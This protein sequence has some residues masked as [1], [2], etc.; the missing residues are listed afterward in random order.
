MRDLKLSI[1]SW[2]DVFHGSE[3]KTLQVSTALE[4]SK[5]HP[6]LIRLRTSLTE[7]IPL[8]RCPNI[9]RFLIQQPRKRT[10]SALVSPI[11][12][13]A[14]TPSIPTPT[15]AYAALSLPAVSSLHTALSLP[16]APTAPAAQSLSVEHPT[17]SIPQPRVQT[18]AASS[19]SSGS[20]RFPDSYT[21]AEHDSAW[22]RFE[23]QQSRARLGLGKMWPE[24]FPGSRYV[25]TTSGTWRGFFTNAVVTHQNTGQ[26]PPFLLA[27]P[28]APL[29]SIPPPA[30]LPLPPSV[31]ILEASN[32]SDAPLA[33]SSSP[34]DNPHGLCEFCDVPYKV[35]PSAKLL[36][37]R[38]QLFLI[39]TL[40][41]NFFNPAHR[42][43]HSQARVAAYCQ[44][45]DTD[46]ALMPTAR[47]HGWPEHI[48]FA[49]LLERRDELVSFLQE[50]LEDLASS[51]FFDDACAEK[52][53][54]KKT[55]Y[56]GQIG[57]NAIE[58]LIRDMF[59]VTTIQDDFHPLT[60]DGLVDVLVLEAL[61][62][63]I[64]GQFNVDPDTAALILEESTP[65]GHAYHS[66]IDDR[67]RSAA[68]FHEEAP[69][70]HDLPIPS[71]L[72]SPVPPAPSLPQLRETSPSPPPID[73][74][75][76]CPFCDEALPAD[77]S[78]RL[79]AMGKKLLSSSWPDPLPDNPLHRK[80]PTMSLAAAYCARHRFEHTELQ[81]ALLH[82]WPS[83][84]DFQHL[85]QRVLA[86]A[87][88]LRGVIH[89]YLDS[90][91]FFVAARA[92]YGQQ[93]SQRSTLK[94]KY[95]NNREC[96][97]GT[98]YYGER[99][100]QIIYPTLCFLFP[101]LPNLL[102][103]CQPLTYDILIREVL[104]PEATVRLIQADLEVDHTRAVA[105]LHESYQFGLG[106]HQADDDCPFYSQAMMCIAE[107]N[108]HPNCSFEEYYNSDSELPFNMWLRDQ[109]GE[110][111]K[112][113]PAEATIP[114]ITGTCEVIDLTSEDD[115]S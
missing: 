112:R 31:P 38:S 33:L 60:Y 99:G 50:I 48:N 47:A 64:S 56:F 84:P 106:L 79:R 8:A 32:D 58:R 29:H 77:S 20:K 115:E 55:G 65:F 17:A 105:I 87:T 94:A 3:W 13:I 110:A 71:P 5:H 26:Y 93:I 11:K 97:H 70:R 85:F 1:S 54:S 67:D 27:A 63:L 69:E 90:N 39:S 100:Y 9:D 34:C 40:A 103:A 74:T 109:R 7:D 92:H 68:E 78:R 36:R 91:E 57:Y 114:Q 89:K 66:D 80:L 24:L 62:Y 10:G 59:H 88:C 95:A 75:M 76:L 44:Q 43:S 18:L 14:H 15:S 52:R 107:S 2:F 108:I 21:V 23:E 81:R 101:D 30:P 113:E 61:T 19:S 6:V 12:K 53:F 73:P 35:A 25:K 42:I 98:G 51:N 111:V 45:H 49:N 4:V 37:I 46:A 96:K 28:P 16:A 82:G 102:S 86:L 22:N 41:P 83:D 104:I 72:G